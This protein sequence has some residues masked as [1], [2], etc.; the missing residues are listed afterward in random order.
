MRYKDAVE[1]ELNVIEGA[2]VRLRNLMKQAEPGRDWLDCDKE[3]NELRGYASG[4]ERDVKVLRGRVER[5]ANLLRGVTYDTSGPARTRVKRA[6]ALLDGRDTD[7]EPT[8]TERQDSALRE[9]RAAFDEL[10]RLEKDRYAGGAAARKTQEELIHSATYRLKAL[11]VR[12]APKGEKE[13]GR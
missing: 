5:A 12:Y 7:Q 3:R 1:N 11:L 6:I 9:V 13:A 2:K 10:E 8:S 4:L